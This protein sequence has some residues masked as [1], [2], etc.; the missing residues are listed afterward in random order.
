MS[1]PGR[2]GSVGAGIG[3]NASGTASQWPGA[4]DNAEAASNAV[5][6]RGGG[7]IVG[8]LSGQASLGGTSSDYTVMYGA[9]A[10]TL[11]LDND[12]DN[13]GSVD[14]LAQLNNYWHFDPTTPVAAGKN[15]FYSVAL[16]EMIH[17]LGLGSSQSWVTLHSGTT[18][19]G[20]NAVSLNGGTGANLVS[21]DGA[22]I[23]SSFMSPRIAD[24]VMQEV[25]MDP[26]ILVGTRKLLTQMDLAFLRDLGYVTVPE[27]STLCLSAVALACIGLKRSR[28]S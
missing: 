21:S 16:H 5:M 9:I 4:L 8:T 12:T 26:S 28:P 10:G 13:N 25:V 6:P 27:P 1:L 7:P 19:L 11:K 2:G 15:D 24:G 18:W 3:L 23:A 20:G 17:G 22:H 14:T